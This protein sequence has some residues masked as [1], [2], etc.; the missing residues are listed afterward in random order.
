MYV[1]EEAPKHVQKPALLAGS[2]P[3]V[4]VGQQPLAPVGQQ[5]WEMGAVMNA[6]GPVYL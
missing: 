4:P 3:M 6:S 1:P 5:P 2:Q